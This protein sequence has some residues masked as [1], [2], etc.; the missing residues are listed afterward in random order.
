VLPSIGSTGGI[1][2]VNEDKIDI[3]LSYRPL[4]PKEQ[5]AKIIVEP[6]GRTAFIFG[7]QDSNRQKGFTLA[8]IDRNI[9]SKAQGLA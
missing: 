9:C 8:E 2:A 7:V 4:K 5:S 6:Y 3:G 1:K